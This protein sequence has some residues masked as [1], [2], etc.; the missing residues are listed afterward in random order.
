MYT[1][2]SKDNCPACVKVKSLLKSKNIDFKEIKI[3]TNNP[4]TNQIA[5]EDFMQKFPDVKMVP[6]IIDINDKIYRTFDELY[7]VVG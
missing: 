4:L 1:V 6:F 3:V 2:Y 7:A 5:R